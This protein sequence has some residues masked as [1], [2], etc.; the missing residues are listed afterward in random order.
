MRSARIESL[1]AAAIRPKLFPG[2]AHHSEK[3]FQFHV[4]A[5]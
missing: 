4:G 2:G 3:E 1:V 5:L